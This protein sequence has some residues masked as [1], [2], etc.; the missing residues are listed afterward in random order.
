MAKPI[1]E[2]EKILEYFQNQEK[3]HESN[4]QKQKIEKQEKHKTTVSK[5]TKKLIEEIKAE[6]FTDL[7]RASYG[8]SSRKHSSSVFDVQRFEAMMRS[9]LIE[10]YKTKQSYERPYISVTELLKCLRQT[11]Y[12]RKRYQIDVKSQYK[13]AY[14]YMIQKV[15]HVIHGVFQELYDFSEIEKTIV[16]DKYKVKGR[17]D[18]IKESVVYEIKTLDEEKFSGS[19]KETD[20]LQAI[21][22]AYVLST[23]YDYAIDKICIIYMFRNL[24]TP[25]TFDL[26]T[27]NKVAESLLQRAPV[28]ISALEANLVIDPIAATDEHCQYCMYKEYCKKDGFT[29]ISPPYLKKKEQVKKEEKKNESVFLL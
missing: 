19:Y 12:E 24:R 21:I 29:K 26:P 25:R 8:K 5:E 23:E 1:N 17:I 6:D 4:T 7:K 15:A 10:E 20:Y 2:Y 22:Y 18:A 14:L 28:L 16:S 3:Q 27:N 13:F 11:Y 9:K